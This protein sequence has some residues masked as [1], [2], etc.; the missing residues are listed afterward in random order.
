MGFAKIHGMPLRVGKYEPLAS[1][2]DRWALIR[3][4]T[5]MLYR[6]GFE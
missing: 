6:E 4:E 1:N 3:T 2:A 5:S